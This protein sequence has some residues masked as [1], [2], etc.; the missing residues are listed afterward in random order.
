MVV[1]YE[2]ERTTWV[3]D[4]K[5]Y[6][7]GMGNTTGDMLEFAFTDWNFKWNGGQN[8]CIA[9]AVM[10][11]SAILGKATVIDTFSYSPMW[12]PNGG[13]LVYV[14]K[15]NEI[16]VDG[17]RPSHLVVYEREK[18]TFRHFPDSINETRCPDWKNGDKTIV[19]VKNPPNSYFEIWEI[20]IESGE[21]SKLVSSGVY[22][23]DTLLNPN[24]PDVS[25]G[26]EFVYFEAARTTDHGGPT[27]IWQYS[28]DSKTLKP[29]FE[30]QWAD[31]NPTVSPNGELLAFVSNRSGKENIWVYHFRSK[32]FKQITGSGN[33]YIRQHLGRISWANDNTLV[34]CGGVDDLEGIFTVEVP[35][36]HW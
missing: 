2:N 28:F 15:K 12:T 36:Y 35:K 1:P 9:P 25:D 8:C 23:G 6:A 5:R 34:F 10:V 14:S 32:T 31:S 27:S 17:H 26:D 18:N 13:S 21:T 4:G 22:G 7:L 19:Y 29:V 16:A 3:Y 20:G 33:F 11:Y 24:R 30:T